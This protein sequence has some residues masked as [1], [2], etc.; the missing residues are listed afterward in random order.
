MVEWD[1]VV[2]HNDYESVTPVTRM[3][4]ELYVTS[5]GGVNIKHWRR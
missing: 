3:L 2:L 5:Y 4:H 1:G